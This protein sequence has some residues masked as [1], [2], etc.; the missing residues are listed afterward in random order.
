[1]ESIHSRP[2]FGVRL[3]Q[4][5]APVIKDPGFVSGSRPLRL[6]EPFA[7]VVVALFSPPCFFPRCNSN[8]FRLDRKSN[9]PVLITF[10]SCL[11][12]IKRISNPF[13]FF[14]TAKH[15]ERMQEELQILYD[16]IRF[17]ISTNIPR[18]KMDKIKS[19]S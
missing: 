10:L 8:E 19:I 12:E 1:M 2:A 14:F 6:S 18:Y 7:C 5:G 11:E 9:G 17:I 15:G 3:D 16:I 4:L 13:H